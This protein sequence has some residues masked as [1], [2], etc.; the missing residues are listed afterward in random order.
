MAAH[1][2]VTV[3][4]PLVTE[5]LTYH[6]PLLGIWTLTG[7]HIADWFEG[8]TCSGG[9]DAAGLPP[10]AWEK[11]K[12]QVPVVEP[13]TVAAAVMLWPLPLARET[14]TLKSGGVEGVLS[15][16]AILPSVLDFVA[17]FLRSS[18]AVLSLGLA[19]V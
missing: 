12:T 16:C 19:G 18:L 2:E 8:W 5:T 10:S 17:A 15:V 3:F 4:V 13:L 1:L 7:G 9:L 14:V 6:G 11:L